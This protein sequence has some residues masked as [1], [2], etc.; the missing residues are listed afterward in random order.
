MHLPRPHP[1]STPAESLDKT[2]EDLDRPIVNLS[3]RIIGTTR[4]SW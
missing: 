4:T 2:I 3:A 1:A